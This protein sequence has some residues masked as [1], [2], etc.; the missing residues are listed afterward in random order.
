MVKPLIAIIE[1]EEDLLELLEFHLK[2]ADFEV[3]GF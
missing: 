2:K 1:D 3:E